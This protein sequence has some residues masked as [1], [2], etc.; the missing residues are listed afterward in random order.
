M[1]NIAAVVQDDLCTQCGTCVALCPRKAIEAKW[2]V[3]DGYTPQVDEA[4]CNHC[5]TCLSVC[6]G[7]GFDFTGQARWRRENEGASAQD[8]L[9]PWRRL[10]FGWACDDQIRYLGASGGVATALLQS[11]LAARVIDAAI[12][13]R[14]DPGNPLRVEPFLATTPAEIAECRG[15]KYNTVATNLLLRRVIE[16]PARYALIGLPC[17]I[18]GFDLAREHNRTVRERVVLTVGLFCGWTSKPR[19]TEVEALRAGLD[20]RELTQVRY[21]GCGWP[22]GLRYE[23][24]SG[25]VREWPM[26]LYFERF[27]RTNTLTRCRL[28]P[29][30]L[31]ELADISIGD[32]WLPR[33]EGTAGVSDLVIRTE[34]GEAFIDRIGPDCLELIEASPDEILRSQTETLHLKRDLYRGRMWLRGLARRPL[35]SNPGVR[36]RPSTPDKWLALRDF[37][38][39]AH[40]YVEERRYP[41]RFLDP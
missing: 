7:P 29:D 32:A 25:Q 2:S 20:P 24:R 40:R 9:G 11:A 13:C 8:F 33:F 23:T 5:D 34:R 18:Q 6:P 28:C 16:Q 3:R 21:R 22:G 10:H 26:D 15:S 38:K 39:E 35:P 1:T 4:L 12:V 30:G 31:A 19:A 37:A 17:H 41:S 14:V 27:V 36:R